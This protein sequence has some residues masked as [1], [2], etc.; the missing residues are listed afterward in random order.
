MNAGTTFVAGVGSTLCL[1]RTDPAGAFSRVG[2]VAL[3]A[4]VQYAWPNGSGN[5]LYVATSDSAGRGSPGV[6]HHLSVCHVNVQ[7]GTLTLEHNPIALPDRPIHLS[8]DPGSAHVLV[9][10]NEPSRVR[11]YRIGE[12]GSIT[13][14]VDQVDRIRPGLYTHQVRV[15][16]DGRHVAA[17]SLGQGA[18]VTAPE[19]P[20]A[21]TTYAYTDGRLEH[22]FSVSLQRSN[23]FGPRH[24]DFHPAGLWVYVSVER[25]NE[26]M[27]FEWDGNSLNPEPLYVESTLSGPVSSSGS[28]KS[29]AIHVHPNGRFVYVANR[30]SPAAGSD[31]KSRTPVGQN[32]VAVFTIDPV[33][34]R[35]SLL[36]TVDT[37]GI[38]C[39]AFEISSDGT[40]LTA[41]HVEG[42]PPTI[43]IFSIGD[44]GRLTRR[45][46]YE[47][48][49]TGSIFWLGLVDVVGSA[50]EA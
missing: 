1:Y 28:Q 36:Q 10:F 24:L 37:G 29:G 39:R 41:G 47:V 18:S 27:M 9:A 45:A 17:V 5:R 26:I 14:E 13:R 12:D 49:P 25:Q 50:A 46:T 15:T 11:V 30:W 2:S 19:S 32:T 33:S 35:P 43:G 21:L 8:L 44:D 22:P 3:P 6:T 4:K 34:G 31:S 7:A 40:T 16:P 23:G 38:H 20:G 42:A 48:E